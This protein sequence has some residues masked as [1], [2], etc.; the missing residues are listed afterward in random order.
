MSRFY[1]CFMIW[2]LFGAFE[3]RADES[4]FNKPSNPDF[5][6]YIYKQKKMALFYDTESQLE[7]EKSIPTFNQWFKTHIQTTEELTTAI[8]QLIA[9]FYNNLRQ[10][11]P[12]TYK[13]LQ[14]NILYGLKD[15]NNQLQPKYLFSVSTVYG[16]RDHK[17]VVENVVARENMLIRSICFYSNDSLTFYTEEKAKAASI[18]YLRYAPVELDKIQKMASECRMISNQQLVGL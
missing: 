7:F 13:Y 15:M 11:I 3:V 14:P 1:L 12:G 18:N 6:K 17:C 16:M 2:A 10:C 5:Q 4:H 9:N 8:A